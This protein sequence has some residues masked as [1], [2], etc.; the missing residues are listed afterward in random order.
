MDVGAV[1]LGVRHPVVVV[2]GQERYFPD[3]H[4]ADYYDRFTGLVEPTQ[5][6]T[7]MYPSMQWLWY[8]LGHI[9]PHEPWVP[10]L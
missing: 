1:G 3:G 7:V 4:E 10:A 9:L 6:G 2:T 5:G 8:G